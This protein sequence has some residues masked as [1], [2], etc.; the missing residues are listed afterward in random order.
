MSK[1]RSGP[2]GGTGPT[3]PPPGTWN[4]YLPSLNPTLW[5]PM[6]ESSGLV[7]HDATGNGHDGAYASSGVTY[8]I[9]GPVTGETAVIFDGTTGCIT[10]PYIPSSTTAWS[11]VIWFNGLPGLWAPFL[12]GTD[13]TFSTGKGLSLIQGFLSGNY[14]L[15]AWG[16]ADIGSQLLSMNWPSPLNGWHMLTLTFGPSISIDTVFYQRGLLYVDGEPFIVQAEY[17]VGPYIPSGNPL[18]I[19]KPY[20]SEAYYP[21]KVGQ[22]VFWDGIQ[23]TAQQIAYLYGSH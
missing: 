1:N 12:F 11:A 2:G 8:G 20:G 17:P 13:F 18:L 4:P 3:P 19:G 22:F 21:G 7:A 9:V 23:L 6:N 10:S 16:F 15:E 14:L 5:Y